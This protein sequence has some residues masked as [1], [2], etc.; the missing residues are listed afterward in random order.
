MKPQPSSV[1]PVTSQTQLLQLVSCDHVI[2]KVS[3]KYLFFSI[4]AQYMVL[5]P[6]PQTTAVKVNIKTFIEL[7]QDSIPTFVWRDQEKSK[8]TSVRKK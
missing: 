4:F 8:P 7:F 2:N 6:S 5:N 1:Q 3:P